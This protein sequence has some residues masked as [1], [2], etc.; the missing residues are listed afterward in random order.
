MILKLMC[1]WLVFYSIYHVF[2]YLLK[3]ALYIY[4]YIYICVCV[5]V[6]VCVRIIYSPFKYGE[7]KCNLLQK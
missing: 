1:I 3:K 2:M 7:R 4:I 5:C 6:C